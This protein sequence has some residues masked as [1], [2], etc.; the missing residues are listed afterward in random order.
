MCAKHTWAAQALRDK[1]KAMGK[2]DKEV[3]KA[4]VT[5]K[6]ADLPGGAAVEGAMAPT[7]APEIKG[8]ELA[9]D[10]TDGRLQEMKK[11]QLYRLMQG[12]GRKSTFLTGPAGDTGAPKTSKTMLGGY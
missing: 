8:P 10:L 4:G 2:A 12:R 6:V 7:K 1:D 11:F 5:G 3:A 9:P